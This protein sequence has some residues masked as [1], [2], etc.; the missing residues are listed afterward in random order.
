MSVRKRQPAVTR[1]AILDAAEA[2]FQQ[3]G[4]QGGSLQRIVERSSLTKGAIFHHFSDNRALAIALITER[5]A[6]ALRARWSPI[7]DED[8]QPLETLRKLA[9]A[10]IELRSEHGCALVNVAN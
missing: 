4:Y 3:Y 6:P 10:E 9:Q 7:I 1:E 2:E 5:H 8:S